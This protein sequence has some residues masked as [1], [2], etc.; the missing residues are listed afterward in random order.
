MAMVDGEISHKKQVNF[1]NSVL[2]PTL[3]F[4]DRLN[5]RR[6]FALQASVGVERVADF[7]G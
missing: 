7:V 5:K 2:M 4:F 3:I 1:N 6:E